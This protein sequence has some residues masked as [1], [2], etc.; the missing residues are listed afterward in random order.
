MNKKR[1]CILWA[2]W[3][4]DNHEMSEPGFGVNS[5]AKNIFL[6][7][8]KRL[9]EWWHTFSFFLRESLSLLQ[10]DD[11]PPDGRSP[12]PYHYEANTHLYRVLSITF[13]SRSFGTGAKLS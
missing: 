1:V 13:N 7:L 6:S 10:T 9:R 5:I 8:R 11:W 12:Q 4:R 3:M 2:P